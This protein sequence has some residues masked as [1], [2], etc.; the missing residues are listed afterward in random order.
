[1]I[2]FLPVTMRAILKAASL[3]SVPLVAKKN[4]SRPAGRT[5]SSLALSRARAVGGVDRP[6]EG[7]FARLLG[8]GLRPRARFLWPRLTHM[9]CA[10]EIEIA[11]ARAVGEPAA[12]GIGDVERLPR[13]LEAPR[14]VVGLPRDVADLV[15][16]KLR[17]NEI[18]GHAAPRSEIFL[19]LR[20]GTELLK[21]PSLLV[22]FGS[23]ALGAIPLETVE[24]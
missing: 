17:A 9:S 2:L 10:R 19:I 11:L 1:M 14:A 16:V 4:F 5:S 22:V 7:Q 12:L 3:A 6:D 20:Q 24:R 18:F 15:G 21:P 23:S 13:L 8:D